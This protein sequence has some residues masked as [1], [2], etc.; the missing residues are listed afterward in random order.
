MGRIIILQGLP[1]AGKSTWA[2]EQC[3]LDQ[4][5]KRI[6][7]DDLRAM[8]GGTWSK[9]FENFVLD[10]RDYAIKSAMMRGFDVIVDDTNYHHSHYERIKTIVDSFLLA[11]YSVEILEFDTPIEECILR[12]ASRDASV[13][14]DVILKIAKTKENN[15]KF[16]TDNKRTF[17]P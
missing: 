16:F 9:N 13:G 1:G 10:I 3:R 4:N 15:A 17:T 5:I 8:F 6:N 11:N 14:A 7:K 12:D 2:K